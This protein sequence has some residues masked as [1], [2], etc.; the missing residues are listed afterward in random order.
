MIDTTG[1]TSSQGTSSPGSDPIREA[2]ANAEAYRSMAGDEQ[3]A[4]TRDMAYYLRLQR[5]MMEEQQAYSAISNIMKARSD[6]ALNAV[7]NFR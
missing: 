7:R 3:V 2:E 1:V 6:A 4:G 5:A